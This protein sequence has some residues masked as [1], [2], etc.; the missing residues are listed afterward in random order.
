MRPAGCSWLTPGLDF[1]VSLFNIFLP[2]SSTPLSHTL[3]HRWGKTATSDQTNC[4]PPSLYQHEGFQCR[5]QEELLKTLSCLQS[6]ILTYSP[7]LFSPIRH[8]NYFK[9]FPLTQNTTYF[10]HPSCLITTSTFSG[11]KHSLNRKFQ[12][13]SHPCFPH[14]CHNIFIAKEILC[15]DTPSY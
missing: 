4:Y 15:P 7:R 12:L 13:H 9:L 3:S 10:I 5:L 8:S 1:L 14:F 6:A 11:E 2:T